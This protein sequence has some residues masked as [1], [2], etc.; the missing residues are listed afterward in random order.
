MHNRP[1]PLFVGALLLTLTNTQT[2]A[3]GNHCRKPRSKYSCRLYSNKCDI[4]VGVMDGSDPE[5]PQKQNQ[6]ASFVVS[7]DDD[8]FECW[9]VMDGHGT[10]GHVVTGFLKEELPSIL[11]QEL[12]SRE[13][14]HDDKDSLMEFEKQLGTLANATPSNTANPIHSRL[15]RTFHRA[16]L[17]ALQN[18]NVPAGRS[19]TTCIVCLLQQPKFT[20]HVAYVGDSRAI[21]GMTRTTLQQ[22]RKK[23]PPKLHQNLI[24]FNS[25]RGGWMLLET[26]F[27]DRSESP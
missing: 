18:P 11:K 15:V 16:H 4:G 24:E 26:Y 13:S 6:D 3:F 1:P 19:G 8:A 27:M 5:R 10:K 14:L 17:A 23:L 2:A 7:L 12:E 9:G 22:L 25:V 21:Y 20:L